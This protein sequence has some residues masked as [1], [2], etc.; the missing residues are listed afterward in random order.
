VNQHNAQL[1]AQGNWGAIMARIRGIAYAHTLPPQAPSAHWVFP[2][3]GPAY[4][5]WVNTPASV[6]T[7]TAVQTQ[8]AQLPLGATA[9]AETRGLAVQAALANTYAQLLKT[10][11]GG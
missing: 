11:R 6:L 1:D 9:S 8:A 4:G 10:A 7:N 3:A 2:N 5:N